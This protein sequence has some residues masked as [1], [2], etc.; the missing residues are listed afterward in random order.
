MSNSTSITQCTNCSGELTFNPAAQTLDCHFCNSSYT[1]KGEPVKAEV[2]VNEKPQLI[3]PFAFAKEVFD[4]AAIQWLSLGDYTPGDVLDSFH[5]KNTKG[6]YMPFYLWTIDYAIASPMG[7]K[8]AHTTAVDL[9]TALKDWPDELID[10][11]KSSVKTKGHTKPFDKIYTLGFE[12]L[13]EEITDIDSFNKQAHLNALETIAAENKLKDTK[14]IVINNIV[15]TKV[16]AAFWT[17]K[18]N[19]QGQNYELIM[20]G[21]DASVIAGNRPVDQKAIDK[22]KPTYKMAGYPFLIGMAMVIIS[23]FFAVKNNESDFL[24]VFAFTGT[25]I[26][27]IISPLLVVFVFIGRLAWKDP[28][29][30]LEAVREQ[31]LQQQL[32]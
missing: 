2:A 16:Y 13:E 31:R 19:Y 28:R 4:K 30:K 6:I 11:A 5:D 8:V 10:F 32:K 12:V 24:K 23:M 7:S 20:S 22:S 14:T 26:T 21:A 1:L 27:F 3:I 9:G 29:K 15:L 17:N 18:Y 25:C